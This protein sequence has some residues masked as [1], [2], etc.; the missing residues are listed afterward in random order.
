MIAVQPSPPTRYR[1]TVVLQLRDLPRLL[2]LVPGSGSTLGVPLRWSALCGTRK[3]RT[4]TW[5]LFR[6]PP[7]T[8]E[9]IVIIQGSFEPTDLTSVT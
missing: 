2:D 6:S 1:S 7:V 4:A 8:E 9:H 3:S 5:V